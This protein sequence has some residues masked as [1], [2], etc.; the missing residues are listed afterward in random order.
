M[1]TNPA[2]KVIDLFH[3]VYQ[4][5]PAYRHFVTSHK[6]KPS[7]IQSVADIAKIP[8][9]DKHSYINKYP[10]QDRL[11]N[12][13]KITDFYMISTSSG[14]SGEPTFWVRDQEIDERLGLKK[15]QLF[16]ESFGL[17]NKKTLCVVNL[18]LGS[19]TGGMLTAKLSWAVAKN[20]KLTVVTPG[21]DKVATAVILK[22][23]GHFY[24]QIIILGYPPFVLDLIDYLHE[25]KINLKK[26]NLRIMCTA[27]RFSERWRNHI[28]QQI[29]L[30]GK[31]EDV[32]GF[33]ACSDTGIVGCESAASVKILDLA[34]QEPS[35]SL[36]LFGAAETPSFFSYD[37]QAKYLEAYKGEILITADQPIPLIRY[38][39]HDRGGILTGSQL[40][41]IS[42]DAACADFPQKLAENYVYIYGRSDA[43]LLTA[44]IYI[45]DI[46]FCLEKSQFH[47]RLSGNF[48]Y[49]VQE[50]KSFKKQLVVHV[51]LKA[52]KSLTKSEQ[53]QFKTEFVKHLL[54]V[55][56]DLAVLKGV[57]IS[58]P[59]ISLKTESE[60]PFKKTK[61]R[62]FLATT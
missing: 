7:D 1:T 29:S 27:E 21:V 30:S 4:T 26:L 43:V 60:N 15:E 34:H 11:Y 62:Y 16:E 45:E 19:W 6:V 47:S 41:Q 59:K 13:K 61:L 8:I 32:V 48:Q 58:A 3:K 25:Q 36:R 53:K 40:Q 57:N 20:Q 10:L 12:G 2:Q 42:K 9:M 54:Q 18:A 56:T 22:N 24:D 55:N 17:K 28:A 33:Y 51:Y 37:P 49:G 35:L 46:R 50:T 38:N 5:S 23:L 39:I 14:S 52:N 44:N 31:R